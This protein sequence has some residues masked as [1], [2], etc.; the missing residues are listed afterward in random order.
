MNE[1]GE[2]SEHTAK[3]EDAHRLSYREREGDRDLGSKERVE[4]GHYI[5]GLGGYSR[6]LKL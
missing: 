2:V 1:P 3:R 6:R 4:L 5:W